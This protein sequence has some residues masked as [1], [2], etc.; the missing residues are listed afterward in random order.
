L[1][2]LKSFVAEKK[3]GYEKLFIKKE[4][5]EKRELEKMDNC[6]R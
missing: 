6:L 5:E 3:M 4:E 2:S 1:L